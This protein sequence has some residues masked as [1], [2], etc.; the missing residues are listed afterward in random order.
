M[1]AADLGL[2]DY[3]DQHYRPTF[4]LGADPRTLK[5]YSA[6]LKH[7][8]RLVGDP[9]LA[10]ITP[11]ILA[12]FLD[13]L[14]HPPAS[15]ARTVQQFPPGCEPEAKRK[16]GSPLK[17]ATVNKHRRQILSLIYKAGPP[18]PRNR[19]ALGLL[20]AVPWVKPLRQPRR[21]PRDVPD[22]VLDR[23]Y[24]GA[25]AA[26]RPLLPGAA[27]ADWWRALV[28][29]AVTTGFRREALLALEWAW[30]DWGGPAIWLPAE[31]DKTGGDRQKPLCETAVKH[32]LRIRGPER[33]IFAW[34]ASEGTWYRQ[35]HAIQRAGGIV[36]HIRLHDLKRAC[37]TRLAAS[38]ASPWAIQAMLDHASIDTS[39]H[40]I[41]PSADLRAAVE[42][43]HLPDVF[44]G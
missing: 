17:P 26:D 22:D 10:S 36:Q 37:G 3:Y 6:T 8:R 39:R 27:P 44:G 30:I 24:R 9:P 23:I 29:T 20:A 32:L 12:R 5:E 28:V 21:L 13:S 11:S 40:Y 18:G 14:A 4:L 41:N 19:D 43:M 15:A 34:P 38:G 2:Q 25:E 31:F 33:L 42:R 16:K 35:W 1:G 7:W